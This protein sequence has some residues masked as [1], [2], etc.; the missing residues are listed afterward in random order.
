MTAAL[1]EGLGAMAR[2]VASRVRRGDMVSV[3]G[4]VREVKAVRAG[5]RTS[6]QPSVVLVFK[7]GPPLEVKATDDLTVVRGGRELR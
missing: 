7:S 5:R 6:E 4:E 2:V 1:D 3:R